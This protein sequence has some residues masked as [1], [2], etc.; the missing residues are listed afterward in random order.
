MR[1]DEH[2][3]GGTKADTPVPS[4][5]KTVAMAQMRDLLTSMRCV[6]FDLPSAGLRRTRARRCTILAGFFDFG[7]VVL[8]ICAASGYGPSLTLGYGPLRLCQIG[9]PVSDLQSHRAFPDLD[10]RHPR[11]PARIDYIRC[12]VM[13]YE[14]H[15]ATTAALQ[16]SSK[17]I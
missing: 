12:H 17:R 15:A 1:T 16:R 6:V 5:A 11:A 7:S 10:H 9:D 2:A 4:R 13:S 14:R 8:L 3:E